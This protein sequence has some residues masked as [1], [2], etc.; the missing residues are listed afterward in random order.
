MSLTRLVARFGTENKLLLFLLSF[1]EMFVFLGL[2]VAYV[3]IVALIHFLFA[4]P[5]LAAETPF[6]DVGAW[7]A[8]LPW[9]MYLLL[10]LGYLGLVIIY[11]APG[12][13]QYSAVELWAFTTF[14]VL[15]LAALGIGYRKEIAQG[16]FGMAAA[17]ANLYFGVWTALWF[18]LRVAV[19]TLGLVTGLAVLVSCHGTALWLGARLLTRSPE[20]TFW[21][22]VPASV[23]A[24]VGGIVVALVVYF[25]AAMLGMTGRYT[26]VAA[27]LAGLVSGLL[28][29]WWIIHDV[30][31]IP[32]VKAILAA[33]PMFACDAILVGIAYAALSMIRA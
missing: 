31:R 32:F 12:D 18:V 8:V 15:L 14:L 25:L 28:A 13:E 27:G 16:W 22:S 29:A 3:L 9:W 17:D 11:W 30:F 21:R 4:G 5:S 10:A 26:S 2:S 19:G 33:L 23:L 24:A 1:V 7:L 6:F 20:A